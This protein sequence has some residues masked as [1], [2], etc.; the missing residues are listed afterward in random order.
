MIRKIIF[1]KQFFK[2][3]VLPVKYP[4]CGISSITND[5]WVQIKSN[6]S[7]YNFNLQ[8]F[9]YAK[10]WTILFD[11]SSSKN[12]YVMEF[13]YCK[14]TYL[15]IKVINIEC[16]Q[17]VLYNSIAWW[18][19]NHCCGR[20]WYSECWRI[21]IDGINWISQIVTRNLF[22]YTRKPSTVIKSVRHKIHDMEIV[23]S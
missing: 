15:P 10:Q 19:W 18:N 1:C 16:K 21:R 11:F 5:S 14:S 4:Q 7:K 22:I 8:I 20:Y 6:F 9:Y 12:T 2:L 23:I 17:I 13:F 3:L